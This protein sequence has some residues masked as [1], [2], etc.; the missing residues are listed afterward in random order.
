VF[1]LSLQTLISFEITAKLYF[2]LRRFSIKLI[3]QGFYR[4]SGPTANKPGYTQNIDYMNNRLRK[5]TK[6]DY[7]G[8]LRSKPEILK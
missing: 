6:N 2:A 4:I 1:F 3:S 5:Y 7:P 8:I